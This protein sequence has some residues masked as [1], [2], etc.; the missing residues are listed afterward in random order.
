MTTDSVEEADS[1]LKALPSRASGSPSIRVHCYWAL[2]CLR[3]AYGQQLQRRLAR[4]LRDGRCSFRT[5]RLNA[6]K[7]NKQNASAY[8]RTRE[9]DYEPQGIDLGSDW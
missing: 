3:H 1:I 4:C 7:S 5:M 2:D 8:S 9:G 6:H